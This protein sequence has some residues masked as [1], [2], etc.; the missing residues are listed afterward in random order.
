MQFHLSGGEHHSEIGR[1]KRVVS[2]PQLD[3]LEPIPGD[4]PCTFTLLKVLAIRR[5]CFVH[6]ACFESTKSLYL[7]S[8][9]LPLR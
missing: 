5:F 3:T 7:F 1:I 2:Q 6:L 9:D 8:H 4:F